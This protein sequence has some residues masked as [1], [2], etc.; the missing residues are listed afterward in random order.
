MN[1]Y[2]DF[3][4]TID[5]RVSGSNL[6]GRELSETGTAELRGGGRTLG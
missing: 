2:G 4:V 6:G 5:V 1:E 3:G